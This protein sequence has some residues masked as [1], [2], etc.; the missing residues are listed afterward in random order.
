MQP[1][2]HISGTPSRPSTRNDAGKWL[3]SL[4][5]TNGSLKSWAVGSRERQEGEFGSTHFCHQGYRYR[6]HTIVTARRNI[7]THPD[8]HKKTNDNAVRW[9]RSTGNNSFG[10]TSADAHSATN[11]WWH[12]MGMLALSFWNHTTTAIGKPPTSSTTVTKPTEPPPG[13]QNRATLR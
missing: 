7:P 6:Q 12:R 9:S 3:F 1:P 10:P 13:A 8:G 2:S 4:R 5:R 11:Q